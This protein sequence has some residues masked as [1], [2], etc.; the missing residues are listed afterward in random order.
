VVA[1]TTPLIPAF[2]R[3]SLSLRSAWLTE[4]VLDY[5]EKPCLGGVGWKKSRE[6]GWGEGEERGE[7]RAG[8]SMSKQAASPVGD[9]FQG[10]P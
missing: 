3:Q 8:E 9:G 1:F 7:G 4:P 6:R 2:G 10:S 5:T